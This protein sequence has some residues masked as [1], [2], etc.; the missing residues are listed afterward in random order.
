MSKK[1]APGISNK[2]TA[3]KTPPKQSPKPV[4]KRQRRSGLN[5]DIDNNRR[6]ELLELI[7]KTNSIR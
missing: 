2:K 1:K 6:H 4:M 3:P 7:L 5:D